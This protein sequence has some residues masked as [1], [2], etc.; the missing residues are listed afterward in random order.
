LKFGSEDEIGKTMSPAKH[1]L[2][3]VEGDA[4]D[5]YSKHE[6]RS[7]KLETNS[8]DQKTETFKLLQS[9]FGVLDFLRFWVYLAAVCF[10]FGA[11]DF[12]FCFIGVLAG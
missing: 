9:E 4:K 1:V 12:G 2:S 3:E 5:Q 11:L 6:T 8:N 10:G 7:T